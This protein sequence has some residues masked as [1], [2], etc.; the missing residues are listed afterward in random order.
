[1]FVDRDLCKEV[2][3]PVELKTIWDFWSSWVFP[4]KVKHGRLMFLCSASRGSHVTYF[5]DLDV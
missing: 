4:K 2:L 5:F 1:M 3:A